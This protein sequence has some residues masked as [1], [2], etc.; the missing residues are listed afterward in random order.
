MPLL[1]SG[2]LSVAAF[3]GDKG[4]D[5][6]DVPHHILLG[7]V[8]FC[9]NNH[10]YVLHT[11]GMVTETIFAF[12]QSEVLCQQAKQSTRISAVVLRSIK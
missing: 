11:A 9:Y 8:L 5:A 1:C 12:Q 3:V 7:F 6:S 2:W 10:P 4:I